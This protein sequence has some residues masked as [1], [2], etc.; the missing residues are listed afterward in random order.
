MYITKDMNLP[1][2]PDSY[3][4]PLMSLTKNVKSSSLRRLNNVNLITL[5]Y[6][7]NKITNAPTVEAL[8]ALH[9]ERMALFGFDR[10]I[11]EFTRYRSAGSSV[12]LK[13][14]FC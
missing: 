11:Y 8:R 2:Q 12:S 9:S 3:I 1:T 14:G 10:I 13:T 5:T 6:N 4:L 7:L